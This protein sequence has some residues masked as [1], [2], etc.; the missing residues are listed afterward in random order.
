MNS[1]TLFDDTLCKSSSTFIEDDFLLSPDL[2]LHL[3]I[4]FFEVTEG[5]RFSSITLGLTLAK[6]SD[7]LF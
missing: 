4:D 6:T 5:L 7:T 2:E 3:E 1:D